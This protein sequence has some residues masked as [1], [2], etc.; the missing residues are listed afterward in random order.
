VPIIG[1]DASQAA[2]SSIVVVLR[3]TV[4]TATRLVFPPVANPTPQQQAIR[5]R[6]EDLIGLFA[7]A[8]DLLLATG[9]RLSRVVGPED[10]YYPI[11]SAGD[12]FEL[13]P[14]EPQS[15]EPPPEPGGPDD[16]A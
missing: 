1:L 16:D 7:P 2:L 5:G 9:D 3:P 8:L 6:F 4:A 13:G 11:R 14:S 12:A 15:P 10:E